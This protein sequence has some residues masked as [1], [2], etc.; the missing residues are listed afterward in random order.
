SSIIETEPWG[1]ESDSLFLNQALLVETEL[2]PLEL[3]D[4]I[5]QIEIEVG[6]VKNVAQWSSRIIDIDILCAENRIH[7]CERLTIP[8]KW[9]HKRAFA[10]DPLCELVS[11]WKHPLLKV[12]YTSL[13]NDLSEKKQ[14]IKVSV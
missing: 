6:R 11:D 3:L 2:E 8:H 10:L 5:Q 14:A 13:L 4:L 7:H 12:S 1:F 9:L